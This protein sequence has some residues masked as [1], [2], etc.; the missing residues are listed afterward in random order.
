MDT[1]ERS[2]VYLNILK[3]KLIKWLPRRTHFEVKHR[4]LHLDLEHTAE[5]TWELQ[6]HGFLNTLDPGL[7]P[8]PLRQDR[9]ELRL[10]G[11]DQVLTLTPIGWPAQRHTITEVELAFKLKLRIQVARLNL[12]QWPKLHDVI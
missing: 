10:P 4:R 5:G 8:V 11:S 6:C 2:W 1:P 12:D 3:E 9:L 7:N